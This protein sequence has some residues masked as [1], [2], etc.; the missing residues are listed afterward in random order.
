MIVGIVS[1]DVDLW[2]VRPVRPGR[3]AIGN[4][5]RARETTRD[6]IQNKH[7]V[8]TNMADGTTIAG[9]DG[10]LGAGAPALAGLSASEK[11]GYGLGDAGGTVI[12]ALIG[13][14]LTFFYTDV[15]GLAPG[16][17]GTIFVVLRV[18][19][20]AA[21]PLM[22]A[23]ADRTRSRWGRFR[24]W[25]LWGAL[26]IGIVAIATFA[27]PSLSYEWRIVYAFATY[28]LLSVCY[29]AVNVP[30]CAMINAMTTD[31]KEVMSCQTYRFALCGLTGFLVST[32]VPYFVKQ[33]G[34]GDAARGYRLTIAVAALAVVVMLLWC[35]A[36]VRERVP[37]RTEGQ[38]RLGEQFR[39]MR[40]NDQLIVMLVM[41]FLL[42]TIFNTKGGAYMYF[43]TYVL[44]GDT[45]YTS[46]FFGVAT[47]SAILGT[48]I[49][50]QLS[51][52]FDAKH[53]Y[54]HTNVFLGLMS[55]AL[56]WVPASAQTLW[57]VL[58]LVYC[59]VL[60]FT[61][62][63][64]FAMMAYADDYGDWKTGIRASGMNFAFNLLFIKLA[65]AASAGIITCVLVA[66]AYKAGLENQTS[67][68]V[69]G[70]TL[71]ATAIP[72]VIHLL[73]AA[74]SRKFCIDTALLARIQADL[75][76]RRAGH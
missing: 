75:R 38:A 36:A 1:I 13:N 64:H 32:G 45:A 67:A 37:L 28:L 22:G 7:G 23:L 51:K 65:W 76:L 62:P 69:H 53:L 16:I 72:G 48:L 41:S 11:F 73:L 6:P 60:G 5:S 19:D 8:E 42:I 30:Y 70:I 27:S 29:T 24:P 34:G 49:V 56:Y 47:F 26:P 3:I 55:I 25:Q 71:L 4:P 66:V 52:R 74:V 31:H 21:D 39:S 9:E 10:S 58:I 15:F 2:L 50:N 33:F 61:L 68:S 59:T 43:I 46:L 20:A 63:L 40:R 18:F 12:T 54:F 35:F 57:L 14:F 44:H 17:V